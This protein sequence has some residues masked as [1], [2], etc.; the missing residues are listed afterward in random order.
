[1]NDLLNPI[2]YNICIELC[3]NADTRN[4]LH[5]YLTQLPTDPNDWVNSIWSCQLCLA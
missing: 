2:G 4:G 1:M 5:L 3:E